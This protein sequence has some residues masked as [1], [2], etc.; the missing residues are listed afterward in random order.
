[1]D[2]K[3]RLKLV[4]MYLYQTS[5]C[6][7]G[8]PSFGLWPIA[9]TVNAVFILRRVTQRHIV[10]MAFLLVT[11]NTRK[12]N[13]DGDMSSGYRCTKVKVWAWFCWITPSGGRRYSGYG[14]PATVF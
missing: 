8:R 6:W 10:V 2:D 12:S 14:V 1:M 3:E 7:S 13:K 4:W 5:G 11:T 9:L